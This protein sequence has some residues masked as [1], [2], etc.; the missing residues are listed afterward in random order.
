MISLKR[1]L[2]L[3]LTFTLSLLILLQWALITL[4]IER[5]TET[6]LLERLESESEGLLASIE[7][8]PDGSYQLNSLR[9]SSL[10]QR[11]FSGHYFV[12]CTEQSCRQSRSLWDES[13]DIE[14]MPSGQMLQSSLNGPNDERL[15]ALSRGYY[16]QN[17]SLTIMVAQNISELHEDIFQFQMLYS[18]VSAIGLAVLLFIQWIIVGKALQ[19]LQRIQNQLSRLRK[20]ETAKI[21]AEGPAEIQPMIEEL[22]RLLNTMTRKTQRSRAALGN[23][24]H[25]LKTRLTLLNQTAERE[26]LKN[27]P[28]IQVSLNQVS[29]DMGQIIERELKRARLLGSPMPG[30][31]V[32]LEH[33]IAE[34]SRTLQLLYREK[35]PI[36]DWEIEPG[37]LFFGDREDL[38]E[39]LGN[40][41][42]NACKWCRK[43]VNINV[44][45]NRSCC[46]FVV[47]DDGKGCVE[48]EQSQLV[49][50]GFR[51]DESVPGSGLGLAIVADIVESYSGEML[52]SRSAMGGLKVEIRLPLIV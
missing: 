27:L 42:E 35:S 22:N 24:A 26:G 31:K 12:V 21:D 50:R 5:V 47:E 39:M 10:Y 8:N 45:Q 4:V 41:L 6:Q 38:L 20:G 9:L 43:R 14:P 34:L 2:S 25:A 19:P 44:Y 15:F 13:L 40:L 28:E 51:A 11:P 37:L 7:I 16:K 46:C 48:S 23:L 36:I 18:L 1:R 17:H 33:E 49:Q 29:R 3:G 52:F 32:E 30:Q